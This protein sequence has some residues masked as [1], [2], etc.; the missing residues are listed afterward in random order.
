MCKALTSMF[1]L[2]LDFRLKPLMPR[3]HKLSYQLRRLRWTTT[4]SRGGGGHLNTYSAIWSSQYDLHSTL[5]SIL[6]FK[7]QK[8]S[9]P[10]QST[11]LSAQVASEV[12]HAL[13]LK[14]AR[15]FRVQAGLKG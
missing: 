6:S 3:F 7:A 13:R 5:G 4:E 14:G 10:K 15:A 9:G 11:S 2:S 1:E 8:V 12:G